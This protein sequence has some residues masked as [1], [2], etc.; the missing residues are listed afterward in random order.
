M[1]RTIIRSGVI[2][3]AALVGVVGLLHLPAARPLLSRLGV[4]CPVDAVSADQVER[5]HRVAVDALRGQS[6]APTRLIFGFE[7]LTSR[8]KDVRQSIADRGIACQD[9]LRGMRYLSCANV[10][11]DAMGGTAAGGAAIQDLTFSFDQ[12]GLLVGIDVL[13]GGLTGDAAATMGSAIEARL[14][15]QLGDP[16]ERAG[17]FET[18]ARET[19]PFV[20]SYVKY[21]FTDS[22]MTLTAVQMPERG[23]TVREQYVG[24]P[25]RDRDVMKKAL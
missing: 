15:D 14:H 8:E 17:T 7:L 16:T 3:V 9:V 19:R 4:S 23:V 12:A 1:T 22:L 21:R 18:F 11:A 5:M 2:G 13:R 24:V 25:P 20:T 10:A 6:P